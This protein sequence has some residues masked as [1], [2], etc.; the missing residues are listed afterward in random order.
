MSTEKSERTFR[1]EQIRN[2]SSN[3]LLIRGSSGA[4]SRDEDLI[5]AERSE[6]TLREEAREGTLVDSARHMYG[7][8]VSRNP[9]IFQTKQTS[10]NPKIQFQESRAYF[11][12]SLASL[13][14]LSVG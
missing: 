5:R 9:F 6:E 4:T 13:A 1:E 10:P 3:D 12:S 14:R 7:G 11:F 8:R 2:A